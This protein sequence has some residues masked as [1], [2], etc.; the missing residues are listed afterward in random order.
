[1]ADVYFRGNRTQFRELM[2]SVV[3][4]LS[5]RGPDV[6]GVAHGVFL[7]VGFAALGDIRND[8]E[9]KMRGG[10][11]ED[12]VKWPEL[13]PQTIARRRIGP[14][15]EK[16]PHIAER[17]AREREAT[18]KFKAEEKKKN[19]ERLKSEY[20][21]LLSRF[22]LSLPPEEARARAKQI[23]DLRR[24]GLEAR[25]EAVNFALRG[26]LA[27]TRE[28][29][30]K[31][32]QVLSRRRV[33]ILKD[34]GVGFISLSQGELANPG[35]NAVYTKPTMQ[36][37][38]KQAKEFRAAGQHQIFDKLNDGIIIGTNVPYMKDHQ[39]GVGVKQ[40]SFLPT[41]PVPRVWAQR[42]ADAGL[43]AL[44]AGVSQLVTA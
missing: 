6:G 7:S 8:Y 44:A 24:K 5:G 13:S 31:R 29:G 36:G 15:D 40:R 34:T 35:P 4:A 25:T 21:L 32:W 43:K 16:L 22:A 37:Q 17:L 38:S 2:R 1:M 41:G 14:K 20:K 11:G 10:T 30:E 12:G 42:W 19:A 3:A 18:K 39:D 28:T 27:V 26:K 33:E 9:R 23:I